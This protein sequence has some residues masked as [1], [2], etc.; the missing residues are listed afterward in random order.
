MD[1]KVDVKKEFPRLYSPTNTSF[2]RVIVPTLR[3]L[4]IDGRGDPNSPE[5]GAKM[6]AIFS[7]AYA[8]KFA[9]KMSLKRDY[10]VAPAEALWW[11]DDPA[12]FTANIRDNWNWTI[13]NLVP[14]WIDDDMVYTAREKAVSKDVQYA[15]SVDV[16]SFTEGDSFQML[17]VGP[18]SAEAAK[19]KELHHV[20]MPK[21]E[22]TFAGPHHEIYLSDVRRTSPEKLRTILRQPVRPI[23]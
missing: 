12:D 9:S 15:D 20:L 8:L 13:L 23:V 17:H 6:A 7:T 18:Y 3:Y 19:L 4:A 14:D 1:S 21:A 22:V 10:V 5:F 2:E 16:R 11:A